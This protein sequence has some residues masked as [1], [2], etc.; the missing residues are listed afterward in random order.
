MEVQNLLVDTTAACD[1]AFPVQTME[2][3][4][5]APE[6]CLRALPA[7]IRAM[8]SEAIHQGAATAMVAAQLEFGAV[9]KVMVAQQA[10]PPAPEDE[11]YIDDM[12][13]CI[14]PAANV[15]LAKVNVVEILH[16]R[17]NC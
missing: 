3:L 2:D 17:L 13:K 16:D 5:T 15:V 6:E 7:R 12:F 1:A 8:E 14:E 9:V 11:D 10:F 4:V